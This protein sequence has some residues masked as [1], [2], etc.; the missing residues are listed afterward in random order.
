MQAVHRY[1]GR[2]SDRLIR[3][4]PP[5]A[6]TLSIILS[7]IPPW[8]NLPSTSIWNPLKCSYLSPL[9]SHVVLKHL[10]PGTTY[11]YVVGNGTMWSKEMKF[12]TLPVT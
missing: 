2:L 5:N 11:H 8:I 9:L 12:K 1:R 3:Q 4:P 6:L 7:L 10:K